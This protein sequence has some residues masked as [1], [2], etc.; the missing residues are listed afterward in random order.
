MRETFRVRPVLE[1]PAVRGPIATATG[2]RQDPVEA[3]HELRA[4]VCV[5]GQE[6]S[7]GSAPEPGEPAPGRPENA[8]LSLDEI[9]RTILSDRRLAHRYCMVAAGW[10][11]DGSGDVRAAVQGKGVRVSVLSTLRS[12]SP[13]AMM[14]SMLSLS[15][16]GTAEGPNGRASPEFHSVTAALD[17]VWEAE[18]TMLTLLCDQSARMHQ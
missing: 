14:D 6:A 12:S 16:S 10:K 13:I 7:M 11:P 9:A 3:V 18:H 2:A 4:A 5:K 1:S 17:S 8:P 15:L